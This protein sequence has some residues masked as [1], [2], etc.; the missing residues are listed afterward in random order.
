M[1]EAQPNSFSSAED[2]LQSRGFFGRKRIRRQRMP[3]HQ[4]V[5]FAAGAVV[6]G[7]VAALVYRR[8]PVQISK[9]PHETPPGTAIAVPAF[10]SIDLP[11]LKYGNPGMYFLWFHSAPDVACLTFFLGPIADPLVRKAYVAAYDRRLRH[12]AWVNSSVPFSP[13]P[14]AGG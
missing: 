13:L 3:L 5:V 8:Q 10:T 1:P 11:V 6:G 12:P 7:G 14:R 9:V 2:L 4:A